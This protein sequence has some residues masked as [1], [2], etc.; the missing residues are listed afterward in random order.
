MPKYVCDI[1][2][3]KSKGSE[4]CKIAQELNSSISSNSETLSG[5]LSSWSGM[6]RAT[7]MEAATSRVSMAN[8]YCG[9]AQELGELMLNT[10]EA[11]EDL[12]S[13]LAAQTI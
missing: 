10:A 4:L 5:N 3:I 6:T 8:E 1:E 7:F 13:S 2:L 12:E 9:K 11:I